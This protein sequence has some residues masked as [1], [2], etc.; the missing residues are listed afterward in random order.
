MTGGPQH[1]FLGD[2]L[3]GGGDVHL[4]L[5]DVGLGPSGRSPDLGLGIPASAAE[6]LE[7]TF[8]IATPSCAVGPMDITAK[9]RNTKST[10]T[11]QLVNNSLIVPMFLLQMPS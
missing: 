11:L 8:L 10:I 7:I 1:H 5:R 6:L 4:V 3:N 2:D 9:I